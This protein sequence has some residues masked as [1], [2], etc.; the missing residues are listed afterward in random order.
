MSTTNVSLIVENSLSIPTLISAYYPLVLVVIGTVLNPF[1]FL[2]FCR[3]TYRNSKRRPTLH[4]MRAILIFDIFML[5]GW[6]LDHYLLTIHGF[7]LQFY[8]LTSCK[9]FSFLNHFASE[10]SAWLRVFITFDRYLGTSRVHRTWFGHSKNVL[11]IITCIIIFFFLFNLHFLLFACYYTADGSL[12][13]DSALYQIY[14][15]LEILH[16]VLYDCVPF[17]LMLIFNSCTIYYMT[18]TQNMARTQNRRSQHRAISFTIILLT[19]LFCIM[20][21]PVSIIFSFFVSVT[22]ETVQN[23]LDAFLYTYHVIEFPIYF[24]LHDLLP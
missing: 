7:R 17:L 13:P 16:F 23:L 22:S 14:P 8:T 19:F 5:Y 15:R 1:T 20:T 21:M 2:V 12:S 18:C 6:N 24:E 4:Y 9:F 10:V 3:A 11:I